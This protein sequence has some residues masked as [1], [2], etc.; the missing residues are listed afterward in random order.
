MQYTNL[1]LCCFGKLQCV[2]VVLI[3]HVFSINTCLMN[4][5]AQCFETSSFY[6]T[7]RSC[8]CRLVWAGP[9]SLR[10]ALLHYDVDVHVPYLTWRDT[11]H[12]SSEEILNLS[13]EENSN[14]TIG[15]SCFNS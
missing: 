15:N 11:A 12:L 6:A 13:I 1:M 10:I 8:L 3:S 5:L 14:T 7:T 2:N 9:L 4:I